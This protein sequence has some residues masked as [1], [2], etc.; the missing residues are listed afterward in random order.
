MSG[1]EQASIEGG[2]LFIDVA[3]G[4]EAGDHAAGEPSADQP[5]DRAEAHEAGSQ[6]Q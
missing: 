1:G 5:Q 6:A 3:P 4:G 2:V